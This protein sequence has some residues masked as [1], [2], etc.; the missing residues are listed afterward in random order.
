MEKATLRCKMRVNE[1]LQVKEAGG[2]I[3]QERVKLTA[4]YAQSGEN[5]EW[6]KWT[7]SANFEIS[8]SNPR[9]FGKLSSGH[10]FFVVFIPVIEVE[11]NDCDPIGVAGL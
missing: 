7:P 9:A 6:S 10:E 3:S 5:A 4:V 1:V 8:I 11:K 2:Q